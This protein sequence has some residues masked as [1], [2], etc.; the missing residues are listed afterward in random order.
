M[1]EPLRHLYF[2][3]PF[4]PKLCP[5]CSFYVE[6]GGKNK[7]RAF[8]DALLREVELH[9]AGARPHTIYF[10]G[11]TPSALSVE[12][13]DYLFGGLRDRLDLGEL[14]EWDLEANP[15]TINAEKA[16]LLRSHGVTRLSLGVQS[17]DDGL[18]K[19]LGR[20]HNAEQ[21]E[22]TFHVLRDAGFTNLNVD[23]MFAVPGQTPAQWSATLDRTIALAPEHVSSYC[24]TY[25]EDTDYFRK[26][27]GG[28]Y[29][30]DVELD[31]TLFETTMDVLPAAGYAQYEISNYA[32]P[33]R[34]SR[35]NQ[36]Y[37]RGADY[38]GFGPSAFSTVGARRWQNIPDTAEYT[39]RI[40]AGESAATFTEELT[41]EMR[42]G[43]IL[44]F[45]IRAREGVAATDVERWS[46]EMSEFRAL[47]FFEERT[48]RLILTRRGKMMADAV[49]E[50][51]V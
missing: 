13:L 50:A 8:L 9:A 44:A 26:L 1:A 15:A 17:W 33:G 42:R 7:T 30:Q 36:A 24:L 48:D 32:K 46:D 35:H 5:Y 27:L 4:C 11:G 16:A 2:H 20:V 29:R 19:T 45:A 49:A 23:L 18:L 40:L 21:A 39:R 51:F 34:E 22:R 3:I 47:G 28:E 38:L 10:G 14:I 6:T 12:Q 25:E 43:E 41:A 31:A 37:W